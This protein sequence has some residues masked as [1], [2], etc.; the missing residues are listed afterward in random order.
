MTIWL[1]IALGFS[2]FTALWRTM[3]HPAHLPPAQAGLP[4]STRR[5][6]HWIGWAML[7]LS[8]GLCA[9]LRGPAVG[10]IL[11]LGTL[12]LSAVVLV[13]GLLPYRPRVILPLALSAPVVAL[14]LGW[15]LA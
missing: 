3:A 5:W 14:L 12:T 10:S 15:L 13:L 8:F 7:A 6:L 11:W 4:E 1:A 9:L 2:G